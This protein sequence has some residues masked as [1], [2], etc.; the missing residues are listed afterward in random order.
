MRPE[1]ILGT[2]VSRV[3]RSRA[4]GGESRGYVQ[5]DRQQRQ[6]EREKK[7][8]SHLIRWKCGLNG[9]F[10]CYSQVRHLK[11]DDNKLSIYNVNVQS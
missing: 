11:T 6:D 10:L 5:T 4:L 7:T 3:Q 9:R 2:D 8:T 1:R